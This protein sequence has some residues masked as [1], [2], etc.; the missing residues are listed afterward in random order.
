MVK[1]D[2]LSITKDP[3]ITQ[4]IPRILLFKSFLR[5]FNYLFIWWCCRVY[6]F[7]VF[8]TDQTHAHCRGNLEYQL[9]DH[10]GSPP[11]I[12]EALCQ[13]PGKRPTIYF[14]YTIV[15]QILV[16]LSFLSFPICWKFVSTKTLTSSFFCFFL[17]KCC[18]NCPVYNYLYM[19][20]SAKTI[21]K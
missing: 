8:Q 15:G 3:S 9:S 2:Q 21:K 16:S 14:Y 13:E 12:L 10:Q 18:G 19:Y 17:E 5:D 4:E 20:F 6:G 11:S 7:L 1:V